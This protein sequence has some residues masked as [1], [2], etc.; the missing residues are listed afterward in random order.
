MAGCAL[1]RPHIQNALK[2]AGDDARRRAVAD[3]Y[4]VASP[5][6]L[7][8]EVSGRPEY[9][10]PHEI[11]TDGRIDLGN[12]GRLRVE[13]KSVDGVARMVSGLL[14]MPASA[15]HV[16][17]DQYRSQQIYLIGQV[18]GS[19][20]TIAYKGPETVLEILR[21]AGGITPGAEPDLV[22]VVRAQVTEGKKPELY[23][24]DL[25][26]ILFLEDSRT[27]IVVQPRDQIFVG[28]RATFSFERGVAPWLR[29]IYEAIWGLLP[30]A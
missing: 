9:S 14:D 23:Q 16:S 18:S 22:Y 20:R 15:V 7:T 24:V 27:N 13:G 5:D 3:A 11:G 21:R 29:P 19:Q 2:S 12:L 4:L 25:R 10:G 8:L 6:V 28:E 1:D 17:V 26:A 30:T